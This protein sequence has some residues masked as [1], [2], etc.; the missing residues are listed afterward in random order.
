VTVSQPGSPSEIDRSPPSL[1]GRGD[2]LARLYRIVEELPDHG[3]A[4]VVRGEPGIG[5]SALLAAAS[6][7][8]QDR[9]VVVLAANGV[10]SEAQLPF[11]G[12]HQLLLPS[13]RLLTQLPEPQREALEM[14]FGLAAHDGAPDV[15]LI[16]LATLG[17][18]SELATETPVLLMI[19]DA[20]WLDRSS[21]RALAF[22]ARRLEMEP[23]ALLLAVRD[24]VPNDIGRGWAR[25]PP[26]RQIGR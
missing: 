21:A 7:R 23:A 1:L 4:L 6:R 18:I 14:A 20:H 16:G 15:F 12:L 11:A 10:E 9:G 8:A 22:V 3:E 2:E 17:L 24:G 19:D 5:K 26:H 13:L 25:G